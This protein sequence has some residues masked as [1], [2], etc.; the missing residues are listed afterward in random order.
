MTNYIEIWRDILEGSGWEESGWNLFVNP[1][2]PRVSVLLYPRREDGGPLS[3]KWEV[4]VDDKPHV[5]GMSPDR[6]RTWMYAV[7]R[8]ED[9]NYVEPSS[10]E[11][12]KEPNLDL[13]EEDKKWLGSQNITSSF[14]TI[15][16]GQLSPP[17][18]KVAISVPELV[19]QTNAFSVKRRPGCTP[20]LTKSDPK[21]LYLQYNV[22]CHESYSDP[23]GHDVRVKFD[24]SKVQETQKAND[25]DVQLNC[26]CVAP[27]TMVRMADGTERRI[28][29]IVV[30]DMVLTHKGRSRRVSAVMNRPA[31]PNEIAYA[32]KVKGY[33]D[34]LILSEDHPLAVVRGYEFCACGCG[35][36]LP[37]TYKSV[38]V[39]SRW[40]RKFIHGHY[41][42]G[43]NSFDYSAGRAL[44]RTPPELVQRECL[45]FPRVQW[46]GMTVVDSD[47]ASLLGY[48]LA[49]GDLIR[50]PQTQ[51]KAGRKQ[52]VLRGASLPLEIE[53]KNWLVTGVRFTLNQNESDTLASDIVAK[54][55]RYLGASAE[56]AIK[57]KNHKGR[58]WLTVTIKHPELAVAFHRLVGFRSG[59]KKLSQ[60]IV[61]WAPQSMV[62]LVSSYALGDG[63]FSE[64]DQSVFSTSRDLITQIS[65]FLFSQG[66]WNN[67]TYQQNL[68]SVSHRLNWD[69]RQYPVLWNAMK[70]RMRP[71]DYT[72]TQTRI[73]QP[74]VYG[75]ST[76]FI[77][78]E[79]YIRALRSLEQVEAP[80]VFHDLEIEDDHSFI[81]NG[82]VVHNCPA[83]LYWGAQW[84]L[85]QRDGLLGEP[86]PELVAPTQHLDLRSNFVIC[87]H[88][89][90]VLERI[91]PSV[92][93]NMINIIREETVR[94]N[95]EKAKPTPEKLQK[96][97][98]AMKQRMEIK[99]IRQ[100]KNKKIQ[101]KLLEALRQREEKKNGEPEEEMGQ[102]EEPTVVEREQPATTE[103]TPL[104]V[105]TPKTEDIS[106]I[107]PKPEEDM[108]SMVE[109][110]EKKLQEEEHK[111]LKNQPHLHKGL[112]YETDTEKQE[113]GHDVPSNKDLVKVLKEKKEKKQNQ[114][115]TSLE[116]SLLAAVVEGDNES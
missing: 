95:K 45:Y 4:R 57:A 87:K 48:Y 26:S 89:K 63:Y 38:T 9:P 111:K 28:D 61:G 104:T 12:W 49:E 114:K 64:G 11:E 27:N 62:E 29:Q 68:T 71:A 99:K 15:P 58:K 67:Y 22:K 80:A 13:T 84:N 91:L 82:V 18:T 60:E 109:Q 30:G 14:I 94:K 98:D 8:W 116:A 55:T 50:H 115:R 107:E 83:F 52:P 46:A 74:N 108:T 96:E 105:E 70:N 25:L 37:L 41:K 21:Q 110:E 3:H 93:H 54:A 24:V 78:G 102:P 77:W 75:D 2:Y 1:R 85:H 92:Q 40:A 53:G 113:H 73:D 100:L 112:P 35:L 10:L 33:R 101:E 56:V 7:K 106:Q 5:S 79:G 42:R 59:N 20:Q 39:R 65:T 17:H 47:F 69:Y 23:N 32:A 19:A 97:Q 31:K 36:S 90:A 72:R 34:P 51:V 66:V 16:L 76:N 103:P 86:R 81:A 6:L 44:W 43:D 88:C